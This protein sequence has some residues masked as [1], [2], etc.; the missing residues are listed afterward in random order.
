M[1]ILMVGPSL[2]I[3]GGMSTVISNILNS[4]L[5]YKYNLLFLSSI[6]C[7]NI[8][9]K[10]ISEC[11]SLINY[12]KKIEWADIVHIHMASRRSTFRKMKYINIAYSNN[13]KII[14]HIHGGGFKD[15]YSKCSKRQKASIIEMF[16]K[17]DR[18]VVLTED[19]KNYFNK[20]A[21]PSKITIIYN[22]VKK[23]NEKR[24]E[25]NHNFCFIGRLVKEKGVYELVEAFSIVRQKYPDIKLLIA[26]DGP[27]LNNIKS[28]IAELSLNNSIKLLG[29]LQKNDLENIYRECTFFVLPSYFEAF[30]MSVI[31]A[32]SYG[33]VV[34]AS[35][36]GGIST[37]IDGERNG[38]LIKP[39]NSSVLS[40]VMI[41][42]LDNIK[43]QK[44]ISRV[45]AEDAINKF[46]IEESI[47]KIDKLYQ[48]CR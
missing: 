30:P 21:N 41:S 11:L 8:F 9:K 32:M 5:K 36:V 44:I 15:F 19:W 34:I 27:E 3:K 6:E 17:C 43:K 18:I 39:K 25:F 28:L 31:E 1:N 29:W 26:G 42:I 48:E 10:F 13:K 2:S 20:L 12:R 38:V 37:I 35:N 14:L 16:K 23:N 47:D 40:N 4:K 33:C 24:Q 22:G 46:S 45:S 7:G